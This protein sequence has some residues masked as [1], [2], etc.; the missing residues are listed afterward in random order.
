M[1]K[2]P[3]RK[4]AK[5]DDSMTTAMKFFLVGC[6]AELYLLIVRRYYVNGTIQQ[7]VAWDDYLKVF[8][9]VGVAVLALGAVLAVL[10]KA[11]KD[12]RS[13]GLCVAVLGALVA[14]SSFI[15]RMNMSLLSLLTVIV[16]VVMLMGILWSLYDREC[17]LAL[18]VLAV[19]LIVLWVCRQAGSN[20]YHGTL[21]KIAA[22]VYM[23][24]LAVL[25]WLVKGKKLTK[26]LPAKAA[27]MPVYV[28]CGLSIVTI[29]AA[30]ISTT[31]AYYAMWVLAAVVF[32]LAVYY[33]V[34]Q[35]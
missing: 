11:S 22:A 27:P 21:V 9:W 18:T 19:S 29:A 13:V 12:K 33:T 28:A 1:A 23:V 6:V 15:V 5:G 32:G 10:W 3:N 30:L 34:K 26:L 2:N 25:A 35:L 16:P 8:A 31:V 24:L 7:V 20:I 4:S 14:T 17:A